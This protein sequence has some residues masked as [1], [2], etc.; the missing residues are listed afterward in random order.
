ML[1]E[2]NFTRGSVCDNDRHSAQNQF[3][4]LKKIYVKTILNYN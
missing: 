3:P 1:A 4:S 2:Y